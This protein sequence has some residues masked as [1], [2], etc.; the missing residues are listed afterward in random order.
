MAVDLAVGAGQEEVDLGGECKLVDLVLVRGVGVEWTLWVAY[1]EDVWVEEVEGCVFEVEE[2]ELIDVLREGSLATGCYV[3]GW[4]NKRIS[5]L[6][7]S[8]NTCRKYL[9]P[10]KTK[11][12]QI[13]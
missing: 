3:G 11:T 6:D 1:D 2:I 9:S 5:N 7:Y 12:R 8:E 13:Q 4:I 10:A